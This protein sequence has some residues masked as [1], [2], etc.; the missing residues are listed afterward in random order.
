R[1]CGW[2]VCWHV[3][4]AQYLYRT[5]CT[6]VPE[7][8]Y[9]HRSICTA[10]SGPRYLRRFSRLRPGPALRPRETAARR[11]LAEAVRHGDLGRRVLAVDGELGR[12]GGEKRAVD[13]QGAIAR[14]RRHREDEGGHQVPP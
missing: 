7:P 13:P 4:S 3:V 6:V 8:L 5:I 11:G 12:A 1:R 14:A 2:S 10:V 9:L